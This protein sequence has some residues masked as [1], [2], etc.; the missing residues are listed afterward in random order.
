MWRES[1]MVRDGHGTITGRQGGR[2][3]RLDRDRP[4]VRVGE[5]ALAESDQQRPARQDRT[6]A[7]LVKPS[8]SR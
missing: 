6:A 5:E 4:P 8:R 7:G 2:G 1:G 3:K